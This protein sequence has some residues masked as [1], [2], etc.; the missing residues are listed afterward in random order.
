MLN[1]FL[2]R[3][4]SGDVLG[5]RDYNLT[6]V[7]FKDGLSALRI[8]EQEVTEQSRE[9]LGDD[10]TAHL[11][12][13]TP[14]AMPRMI[15]THAQFIN[16][17]LSVP[18]LKAA[19]DECTEEDLAAVRSDVKAARAIALELKRLILFVTSYIPEGVRPPEVQTELFAMAFALGKWCLL[20]DLSFR[21]SGYGALIEWSLAT[22]Y[23]PLKRGVDELERESPT[24]MPQVVE[25]LGGVFARLR[26]AITEDAL[27]KYQA[28][29]K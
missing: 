16:E 21:R 17:H 26:V 2:N 28:T 15:Y 5:G 23:E 8:W 10:L 7:P 22:A 29:A 24:F 11:S 3:V 9:L 14:D 6:D 1:I 13:E 27:L 25:E 18:R 4:V 20:A 19:L 12:F